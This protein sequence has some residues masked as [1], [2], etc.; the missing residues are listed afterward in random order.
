MAAHWRRL[1]MY[2]YN[3]PE[4]KFGHVADPELGG[5]CLWPTQLGGILLTAFLLIFL[6]FDHPYV[7]LRSYGLF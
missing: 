1:G 6:L 4:W 5:S 3:V 2:F 7:Y